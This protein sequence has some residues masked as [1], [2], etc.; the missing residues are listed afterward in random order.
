MKNERLVLSQK[1]MCVVD[2]MG[3]TTRSALLFKIGDVSAPAGAVSYHFL[4]LFFARVN[5]YGNLLHSG[6]YHVFD[7]IKKH[8]FACQWQQMFIHGPCNRSKS[9]GM[10]P[11]GNNGFHTQ[12][13]Y[14]KLAS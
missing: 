2:S 4:N 7:R 1:L 6:I 12:K 5:V 8:G 14:L 10:P 11:G 13:I 3:N 9:C